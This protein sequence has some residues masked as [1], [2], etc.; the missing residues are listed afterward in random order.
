MADDAVDVVVAGGGLVGAA[1]ALACARAG[2][3]VRLLD[4]HAPTATYGASGFDARTV[5]LNPA[6]ASLLRGMGV[7]LTAGA[8]RFARM[9][10]WEEYGTR[11]IEFAAA[12]VGRS[13]LGWIVEVSPATVALWEALAREPR[14][15]CATGASISDLRPRV[16]SVEVA[17]ADRRVR[18]RL[19]IAADGGQSTIRALLGVGAERFATGQAAIA[20]I[21]ETEAPHQDTAWQRFL[22]DGP[23]ALLPLPARG[24]RHFCSLV[25]SQSVANADARMA[26]DDVA[27]AHAVTAASEARLGPIRAVDRRHRI[28]LE[29]LLAERFQPS[30][31]V[32][33]VGDAARVLHPLAGQ[34]VNLGFEDVAAIRA[35]VERVGTEGLDDPAIWRP[36]ARQRRAR[37]EVMVRA[38]DAFRRVYAL[39]DPWLQWLRNVGVDAVNRTPFLKTQL[40]K[41]ALGLRA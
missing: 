11:H 21:V 24:E 34:G 2:A 33:L 41:E 23:L 35:V 18:A 25:W 14:V 10:V 31:R 26:L 36:Y 17:W 5:A 12:D 32:L 3:S 22:H 6:S 29:Q 1:A 13:E 8:Q 28:P 9:Y 27:F 4:R 40:M 37:G 7:D 20:T 16:D 15:S 39:D 19:L 30:A 38:M